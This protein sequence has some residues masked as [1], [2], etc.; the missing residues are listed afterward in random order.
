MVAR[1]RQMAEIRTGGARG[2]RQAE[3]MAAKLTAMQAENTKLKQAAARQQQLLAQTRMF[4][5]RK[6]SGPGGD[7]AVSTVSAGTDN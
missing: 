1:D 7:G 6:A 4:M 2:N 5:E 3:A